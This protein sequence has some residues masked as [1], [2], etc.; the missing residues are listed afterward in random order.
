MEIL[1]NHRF[2]LLNTPSSV[3]LASRLITSTDLIAVAVDVNVLGR[4]VEGMFPPRKGILLAA[5]R[6]HLREKQ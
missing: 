3:C 6:A 5:R 2:W 4:A 1:S